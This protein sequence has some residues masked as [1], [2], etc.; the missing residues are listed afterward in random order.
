MV[1]TETTGLDGGS[2][3]RSASVIASITPGPGVDS[4]SPTTTTASAGTWA[5]SRTQYSWKWTT[6]RPLGDSSSGIATWVSTR[7]SVIGSSLR[8]SPKTGESQ[9]RQ[10]ASV[11]WESG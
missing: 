10:S 9:R 6:R 11:T 1:P 5:R 7:S 3:T 4:S 8:L 2:R